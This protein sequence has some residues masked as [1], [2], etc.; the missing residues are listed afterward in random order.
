V[1]LGGLIQDEV[2]KGDKRVPVLGSV[3]VLGHLF[4]S[5]SASKRKTNLLIFLKPTIIRTDAV[6]TGATADKYRTIR[7][8][9]VDFQRSRG[10]LTPK[11]D[12]PILPEWDQQ[13]KEYI[14]ATDAANA[15]NA[16][17]NTAPADSSEE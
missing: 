1:V 11:R 6:L 8:Q 14:K 4:R 10:I 16:D 12:I 15:A 9:Q 13:I 2:N 3:P 17:K 7:D 5:Q